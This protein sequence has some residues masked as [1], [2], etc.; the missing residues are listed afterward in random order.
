MSKIALYVAI[1]NHGFGHVTRTASVL[2][3][4]KQ[5]QPDVQLILV[6]QAPRWLLES[7]LG[8]DF[9]YRPRQL[10]I[11]VI[12]SDSLTMDLPATLAALQQIRKTAPDTIAEEVAFIQSHDI[13]LI[14]ADIPPM[15]VPIA[16]AAGV[17]C[18]MMSNF[19]WDLIY[20]DW[21]EEFTP[22]V[23]WI[24]SCFAQCDR[25]FRLPFH[26]PMAIFPVQEDVGL[27]GGLPR[28]SPEDLR[29]KLNI[30]VPQEKIVLLTFG[31]LG[32]NAIPYE[33]VRQF[34]DH[35]FLTLDQGA[36]EEF[37]NLMCLNGQA[38]RPV[39]LMAICGTV[40]SKPGY[41]TFAEACRLDVPLI[42]LPRRD[43][44]EAQYLLNGLQQHSY[45]QI[46]EPG[47]FLNTRWE[48]L[49]RDWVPPQSTQPLPKQGNET[50][51]QAIWD[52][53]RQIKF[54]CV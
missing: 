7:Y 47:E 24:Q 6:T 15:A 35:L 1:T 33:N 40:V 30:Q 50:I 27:T 19:G 31:G 44:A 34:P 9:I 13:P 43:F 16:K 20:G 8:T 52:F 37:P 14:L 28:Y 39:D 2:A 21:G 51:A 38:Y 4:L 23:D 54:S 25:L 22:E 49:H 5:Q 41:G 32:L 3:T 36:A 26:S 46:L 12:Q 11:G 29:S 18:W 48:F 10:D 17:P 45:H 53:Y 42:A